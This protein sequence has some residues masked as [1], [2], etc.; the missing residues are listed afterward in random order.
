VEDDQTGD[1]NPHPVI[2]LITPGGLALSDSKKGRSPCGQ[3]EAQFQPV[4]DPSVPAVIATFE[5]AI[6]AT[7]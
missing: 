4:K 3:L 6:G 2:P 7:L 5:E 1:V